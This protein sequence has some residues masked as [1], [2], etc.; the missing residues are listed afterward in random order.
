MDLKEIVLE[1]VR[2]VKS[3]KFLLTVAFGF[4]VVYNELQGLGIDPFVLVLVALVVMTFII[5]E[6]AADI[7]ERK[8]R[9]QA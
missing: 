6:G 2:D 1:L 4:L 3:R 5:Q 9:A 7:E 8:A